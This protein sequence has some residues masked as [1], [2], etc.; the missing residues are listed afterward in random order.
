MLSMEYGVFTGILV[1][2]TTAVILTA[3][4][5]RF[6]L[7]PVLGYLAVG[8]L[9]GPYGMGW[10]PDHEAI[11]EV[12]EFGVVFLMFT[13]GLEF[14]LSKLLAMKR[15]VLGLGGLQVLFT[16]LIAIGVAMVMGVDGPSAFVIGGVIAMS[17]TAIVSKQLTE[18]VELNTPQGSNA[19]SILLFQDIAVIPFLI[20]IPSLAD[21]TA[22]IAMPLVW[23]MLKAGLVMILILLVGRWLLRPLFTEIAKSRSLEL[24]TLTV[25]LVAMS[26]AGLTQMMGLS[27]A[28]GAFL[29]G[30]MLGE[31]KF[32]QQIEVEIRPFRDVLLGLFFVTIGMLLDFHKL[33]EI[34]LAVTV[35]VITLIAVKT[36]IIALLGRLMGVNSKTSLRTALILAQGGEFGFALLTL[37]I[38]NNVLASN[39]SQ[40]VLAALLFS[41]A[42]APFLIRYNEQISRWLLPKTTER[43][44]ATPIK[45]IETTVKG[46]SDHVI[47]CGYGRVGQNIAR[48]MRME[49]FE[50]F[51]LDMD[52]ARVQHATL[53][54]DQVGYGDSTNLSILRAS[55]LLDAKALIISFNDLPSTYKILQQVRAHLSHLPI[56]VRT[57]DD[58]E[59]KR[60]QI[61]GATEVIPETLEASLTMAFHALVLVGVPAFRAMKQ[62]RMI[63][64]DRYKLLNQVFPSQEIE[65]KDI[66]D[67]DREQLYV[68]NLTDNAKA[69][70]KKISDVGLDNTKVTVTAV[71]RGGIR[72]PEPEPDTTLRAGDVLVLYGPIP[73]L[74]LAEQ[75]LLEG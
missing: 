13:I 60:L 18:Q 20:L 6:R 8:A 39:L 73:S 70:G 75:K 51:A 31:T 12:A 59:L 46:I 28:L 29:A 44:N 2:L 33:P 23:A 4:F 72:G 11:R 30:M 7:P 36:L 43:S 56:L 58:T 37:A 25:L 69:I 61:A 34:W 3:V 1:L 35:L 42:I 74:Q 15:M 22:G 32:R 27:M 53:A 52:P 40:T 63:R 66:S 45:A 67:P 62:L 41:M 57:K 21:K 48:F 49:G 5:R 47:I 19:I 50:Y 38:N 10:I 16:V 26:A 54:G 71:R 68:V 17:S 65:E 55:G 9:V 14:S 24:F 64:A